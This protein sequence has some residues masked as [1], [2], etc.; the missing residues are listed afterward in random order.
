[1][2]SYIWYTITNLCWFIQSNIAIGKQ[3]EEFF[4]KKTFNT[5]PVLNANL[6]FISPFILEFQYSNFNKTL[7]I[8][9]IIDRNCDVLPIV[10]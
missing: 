9:D 5:D 10:E 8:A 4:Y 3:R 6:I 7:S 2:T 1:M